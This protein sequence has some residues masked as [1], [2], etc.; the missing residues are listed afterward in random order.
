MQQLFSLLN[1]L[2]SALN[3]SGD[4]FAHLQEHFFYC[5]YS[6]WYN[7][8]TLLPTGSTVEMELRGTGRQQCQRIVPKAVCTVKNSA[9]ED[10][11]I[12]RPKYVGL[13]L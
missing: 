8:L 2:N 5:T 6:F 9:P 7:T 4:K 11:R 10:G 1:F 3:I 12:C 13:N